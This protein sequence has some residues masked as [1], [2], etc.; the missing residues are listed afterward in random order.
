M[1]IAA[2]THL[3]VQH[4]RKGV[5]HAEAIKDFDTEV[6]EFYPVKTLDYVGGVSGEWFPGEEIS[7]RKGLS[8]IAKEE[9]HAE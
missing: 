9:R 8:V 7:C 5:F 3:I 1:K 6:D 4:R 2:G